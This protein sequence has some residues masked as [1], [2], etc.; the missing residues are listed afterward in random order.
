MQSILLYLILL[1]KFFKYNEK[2]DFNLTYLFVANINAQ[3]TKSRYIKVDEGKNKQVY[4]AIKAKIKN[5]INQLKN[6]LITHFTLR[7]KSCRAIIQS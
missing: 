2:T 5:S 1:T 3:V 7:R 6:L 4:E